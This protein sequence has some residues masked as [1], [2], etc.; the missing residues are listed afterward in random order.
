MELRNE[1]EE[2][3]KIISK[4]KCNLRVLRQAGKQPREWK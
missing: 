3:D 1:I 4:Y 2:K